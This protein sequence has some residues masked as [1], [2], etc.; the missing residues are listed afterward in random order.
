MPGRRPS[1]CGCGCGC[2]CFR[3]IAVAHPHG[4]TGAEREYS[5]QERVR[6][7]EGGKALEKL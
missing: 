7:G 2:L 1:V 6:L 3:L 5:I 4:R